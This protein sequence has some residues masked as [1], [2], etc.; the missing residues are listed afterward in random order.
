MFINFD[1]MQTKT[2]IPKCINLENARQA[3]QPP[4]VIWARQTAARN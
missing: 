3:L 1:V 4:H 2:E